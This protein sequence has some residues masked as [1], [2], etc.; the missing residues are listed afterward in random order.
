[1]RRKKDP[2]DEARPSIGLA[3]QRSVE[4]EMSNLLLEL[5]EMARQVTAQLDTRSAKL[6]ALIDEADRRLAELRRWSHTQAAAHSPSGPIEDSA[7]P[8]SQQ[9]TSDERYVEVYHLADEGRSPLEI[10]QQLS[11]PRGEVELILALR[12]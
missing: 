2:L 4:R 8:D 10:A 1:M 9:P 11:R 3:Q 7:D 6:E 5:S 12:R